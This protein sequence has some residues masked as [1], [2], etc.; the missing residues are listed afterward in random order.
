MKARFPFKN[1]ISKINLKNTSISIK[2]NVI[3]SLIMILSLSVSIIYSFNVVLGILIEQVKEAT[4]QVTRQTTLNM[5][6]KLEEL[7][8]LA[9]DLSRNDEIAGLVTNLNNAEDELVK[10]GYDSKIKTILTD[11][12]NR[13]GEKINAVLLVSNNYSNSMSGQQGV[14]TTVDISKVESIKS[15]FDSKENSR[16]YD[17]YM[18]DLDI[19]QDSTG[20]GGYVVT[21]A[22]GIF[23]STSLKSQGKLFFYL[24]YNNLAKVLQNVNMSYDGRIY[25]IGNNG[26]II[27]N[28]KE[29]GHFGMDVNSVS[30]ED[31]ERLLY[32]DED[33]FKRIKSE[34]DGAFTGELYGKEVLVTFST[35]DV[36][37]GTM[38][39]WTVVTVTEVDKITE[40]V[41]NVA[42]Q[43]IIIGI[44]CLILGIL[45]TW[46]IN[47]DITK[48]IK[49]LVN[50]MEEV[51]K[52]NLSIDYIADERKDE[53]G[54]LSR[55]F[56]RMMK[57][58]NSLLISIK[59]ASD[60]TVDA[61]SNVSAKI[62]QTY[63][64]IQET[65]AIL[66]TVRDKSRQQ[67]IIVKDGREKILST[68]NEINK[69]K[70]T[71]KNVDNVISKSKDI[72][73]D[74]KNAVGLLNEM[75]RNV[76]TAMIEI[77]QRTKD[78]ITTSTE[79]T[80]FTKK[81]KEISE[82][83]KLI[84]LNSAIES[85][86]LGAEGRS[87]HLLSEE[88]RTLAAKTKEL[89]G[90]I[91]YII[92]NLINKIYDTHQ[93][94]IKLREVVEN[95]EDSVQ[96][97]TDSFDKNIA[98]LNEVTR[99]V[100]DIQHVFLSIDSFVQD[101]VTTIEYI[102]TSSESNLQDISDVSVAMSEQMKS[103][104]S[105]LEETVNLLNLSQEL[106]KKAQEIN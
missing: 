104:E 106:K 88:A 28:P 27:V 36:I 42:F 12:A 33:M 15:F 64:S 8:Q 7:D 69:A 98:F 52:G 48:N 90:N 61:S 67:G 65:N 81:I 101:I 4:V 34:K 11:Y 13:N 54:K 20:M 83:T 49:I 9:Q 84:A 38:L 94:V 87:F 1:Y 79:I 56:A 85:A 91:E 71:M 6:L 73:E 99:H 17:P 51:S 53:I 50:R 92:Q 22:K 70:D 10:V 102:S 16:W 26:N 97:I 76:N 41:S 103:Q 44:I 29:R 66:E 25:I 3:I 47:R 32:I 74:N 100:S 62:Q 2:L 21:L 46:I 86:K 96:N 77:S 55:G 82:Q 31:K 37:N 59:S 18:Q 68:Q 75:S 80:R 39:G 35:I 58:L 23:S 30:Q 95:G 57:S 63:A 14:K 45:F 43:A 60:I 40:N 5:Q 72:S 105:L 19:L 24:N 89:S 93:D 78:L